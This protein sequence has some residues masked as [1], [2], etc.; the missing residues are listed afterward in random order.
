MPSTSDPNILFVFTDQQWAGM[1]SC[2]GNRDLCTPAMDSLAARG[3]RLDRAYCAQP[4]CV[5]SR[6]AMS[7]GLYP[8]QTGVPFNY[9]THERQVRDGI[10]WI[11]RLLAD[12][13]YDTGYIGKWH[14]PL[15]KE[16]ADV[17]GFGLLEEC[18]DLDLGRRCDAFLARPRDRPFFLTVSILDPHNCCEY[19]RGG[20]LPG[21][22]LPRPP[23]THERPELPDNAE[24]P[25]VEPS[26]I[27]RE[28]ADRPGVYPTD[29][30]G[31][32]EWRRYRWAYA[33]LTERADAYL[34]QILHSLET[35]GHRDDTLVV[36]TSDHGDGNGA[37]RWNQKQV[38]Y[39]ESVHV[40]FI[41]VD[42]TAGSPGRHAVDSRLV[43]A[44]LDLLPTFCDY[45]NAGPPHG[46][47]G[48]SLRPLAVGRPPGSWRDH[49]VI[50]TRF[51]SHSNPSGTVGYCVVS[52]RYKYTVYNRG[53]DREMLIDLQDDPGE[54]HNLIQDAE[55]K[56]EVE[57][58]RAW[59]AAWAEQTD[60]DIASEAQAAG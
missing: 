58:H 32:D 20:D 28:Q 10:P 57:R 1:M 52:D 59:L 36:F 34:G 2:A 56:A 7:T 19:S 42:P 53:E 29:R 41:V 40:P 25:D 14:Q 33:R 43:N 21:G 60:A 51:G 48:R 49:T 24:P 5:P 15:A 44:G 45:A 39:N 11:G 31:T 16:R 12:A 22:N 8:H 4:L 46:L 9:H 38:L 35:H 50:E 37:H 27:R 23:A 18:S 13:G 47:L 54:M 3:V 55:M 30:W 26:I 17:H 6:G